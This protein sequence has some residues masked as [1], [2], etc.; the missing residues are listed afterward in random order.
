[1]EQLLTRVENTLEIVRSNITA[2]Y[3]W[4][5]RAYRTH[6]SESDFNIICV[7]GNLPDGREYRSRDLNLHTVSSDTFQNNLIEHKIREVECF[8]L[9]NAN[10]LVGDTKWNFNLDL[11]KLRHIWSAVASNSWVKA[12]KKIDV[13]KEWYIGIKSLFHSLRILN[14]ATQLATKKQIN[15]M[16]ANYIW[17]EIR[18]MDVQPWVNIQEKWQPIYNQHCSDFRKTAPK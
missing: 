4:G 13:E 8:F 6:T 1:M 17:E 18:Y 5:S 15:F 14:F 2:I 16:E 11:K 7:G 9:P 3:L 10:C 12:K